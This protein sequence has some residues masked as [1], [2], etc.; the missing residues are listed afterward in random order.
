[1]YMCKIEHPNI[2]RIHD[3]QI[4]NLGTIAIQEEV[5]EGT[6]LAEKLEKGIC[7][8]DFCDYVLQLCD[9]LEYLHKQGLAHNAVC[10]QNI[11]INENNILKLINFD[12]VTPCDSYFSDISS[13]GTLIRDIKEDFIHNYIPFAKNCYTKYKTMDDFRKGFIKPPKTSYGVVISIVVGILF[14]ILLISNRIL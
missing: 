1:M 5:F 8:N 12:D 7:E 10:A 9:A 3:T 2:L 4:V 6:T 14:L 11:L 13:V